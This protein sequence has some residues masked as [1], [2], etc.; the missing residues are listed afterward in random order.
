[1]LPEPAPL[2]QTK[3]EFAYDEVRRRVLSGELAPGSV[4]NQGPLAR[5]IGIST[6]PLREALKRLKAE[7]LVELGAHRDARVAELRAEEARDLVEVRRALDPVAV[8]LAARRRTADDVREMREAAEGLRA[9][10]ADPGP[11]ELAVHR[12]FHAALYRASHNALLVE[13]LDG[14][15]DKTDR[16]R[17]H[18]LEVER[19]EEARA[20]KDR[21]HAALLELVIAGDGEAAAAVMREHVDTSLTAHAAWRLSKRP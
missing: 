9:L 12:R 4:I 5:E 13:A 16:Y 20:R 14:L 1:M 18:A 10:T 15:W 2:F 17:R 21:E 8:D 11:D 3:A 6:T 19:D 7:G